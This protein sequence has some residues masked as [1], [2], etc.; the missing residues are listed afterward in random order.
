MPPPL[1]R[2]SIALVI[3]LLVAFAHAATEV[4]PSSIVREEFFVLE[5]PTSAPGSESGALAV[6]VA[7]LRL[8]T[9][10]EV[11]Q[12][13]LDARF[14][15]D[16]TRVVHVEHWTMDR[17]KLVWR[18]WRPGSG[19][20]LLAE[21]TPDSG[22]LESI[23]WGRARRVRR[24][25]LAQDGALFPLYFLELARRDELGR[26]SYPRFDPLAGTVER[27][28]VATE[29]RAA[30]SEGALERQVRLTAD[31]GVGLGEFV[32]CGDELARWSWQASGLVARRI[33][34][35]EFERRSATRAPL[36]LGVL[37]SR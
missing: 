11:R 15:A 13:E 35:D 29:F 19:R 27:V 5:L 7:A 3:V 28:C 24:E 23:E 2:R 26:G 30:S 4:Q 6:G 32:F 36:E 10:S 1:S 16:G 22:A 14:D 37:E 8:R 21:I 34:Q 33:G 20:T 17:P 12:A 25:V 31:D 18:E 9:E